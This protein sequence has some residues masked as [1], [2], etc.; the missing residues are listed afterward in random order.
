MTKLDKEIQEGLYDPK[1]AGKSKGKLTISGKKPALKRLKKHLEKEHP[2]TKGK[3]KVNDPKNEK[4]IPTYEDPEFLAEWR[5]EEKAKQDRL[6]KHGISFTVTADGGTIYDPK[7]DIYAPHGQ[8][9]SIVSEAQRGAMFAEIDRRTFAKEKKERRGW[10]RQLREKF[11]RPKVND[12]KVVKVGQPY[13]SSSPDFWVDTKTMKHGHLIETL[14][15]RARKKKKTQADYTVMARIGRE[16]ITRAVTGKPTV[17]EPLKYDIKKPSGWFDAMVRGIKRSS[18]VRNPWAIVKRIW[19]GLSPEKKKDILRREA[20]G[21]R[22]NY[23]LP[24]PDDRDTKGTGTLR[25]VKPFKL[26]EAQ[27]NVSAKDMQA[28]KKSG[29]FKPMAREDGSTCMV[30]RCKSK[31]PVNIFVDEMR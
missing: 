14:A 1:K 21:E 8:K 20:A 4:W 10:D 5:K 22:F 7:I 31:T 29:I 30:A 25:M 16:L 3:M 19:E 9:Q 2:S 26:A 12:P 11:H 27:V 6:R 18:D 15:N 13:N 28:V 23:D 24:L 17:A